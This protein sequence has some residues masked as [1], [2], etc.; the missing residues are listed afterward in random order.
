MNIRALFA[1]EPATPRGARRVIDDFGGCY[2]CCAKAPTAAFIGRFGL[3]AGPLSHSSATLVTTPAQP[4]QQ[5]GQMTRILTATMFAAA[6]FP[7]GCGAAPAADAPAE[8]PP[9]A[10]ARA[11]GPA[12][13]GV[14][15]PPPTMCTNPP[16]GML[17]WPPATSDRPRTGSRPGRRFSAG[18]PTA[19]GS[20]N[21]TAPTAGTVH[22][23][24][25]PGETEGRCHTRRGTVTSIRQRP[26]QEAEPMSPIAVLVAALIAMNP[27]ARHR[28][29]GRQ[30][31][32]SPAPGGADHHTE[33]P[34]AWA[35]AH[36]TTGGA[37]AFA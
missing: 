2:D 25:S 18:N 27:Y 29:P 12:P 35:S 32:R 4:D 8:A 19:P 34:D 3:T 24:T 10:P 21:A 17:A 36:R 1:C 5:V 31:E 15:I 9:V 20:A 28:Q 14:V 6:L 16:E 22:G 11:W 33:W 26:D 37:G 30:G 23:P 7:A 13:D